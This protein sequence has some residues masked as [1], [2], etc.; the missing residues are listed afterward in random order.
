MMYAQKR[1]SEGPMGKLNINWKSLQV[2]LNL[3][4][5]V[6]SSIILFGFGVFDYIRL[7][8][9]TSRELS[10]TSEAVTHRLVNSMG[11]ALW[12]LDEDAGALV[13]LSEMKNQ[14][15]YAVVVQDRNTGKTFVAV[16]RDDK[17]W[18]PVEFKGSV[19]GDY[20]RNK[21]E[22]KRH[23]KLLGTVELFITKKFMQQELRESV[24]YLFARVLILDMI[25]LFGM[26][27]AIHNLFGRPLKAILTRV[28]DI[29]GGQGDLTMRI[30]V[31]SRDELGMLADLFNRFLGQLQRMIREISK[32][33]DILNNSS[34]DLI[35]L[36]Q[37]MS[38][39][40]DQMSGKANS[41][42]AAS[43]QMSANINSVAVAMEQAS[44]NVGT[45]AASAQEMTSTINEIS[46]NSEKARTITEMAVSQTRNAS[47]KVD[48][49]GVA[50]QEI[51]KVTE[52]INDISEQT[53]LLALNA[54]IE[55]ARAGDAGKGFAVVANEIKEL[56]KQTAVAT[57]DIKSKVAAIQSTTTGTVE[58]I[59]HIQKIINDVNEIVEVIA[60]AVEEQSVTTEEIARNV[61]Q[62]SEGMQEVNQNVS[63]S[64]T[65][66][67]EIAGEIATVNHA[68]GE[69]SNATAQLNMSAEDMAGLAVQLKDMMGRFKV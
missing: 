51:G 40:T 53:N 23:D 8:K 39:G 50:A 57:Q 20:L 9:K 15:V 58:E 44:T 47:E 42:A 67:R 12:D 28:G 32:N 56:A 33:A 54:T 36:S 30:D 29:A 2:K 41:V 10:S 66:S 13:I 21:M 3:A 63:I 19:E 25:L 22:I 43:E 45:I 61:V 55:A 11:A 4:I 69:I 14:N 35:R 65:V 7:E 1:N 18:E 34:T 31:R 62:A 24:F 60:A 48:K 6:M 5:I 38:Q 68:T 17:T 37:Q 59:T 16:K 27:L 46:Q 26:W 64:N 49:L 52:A